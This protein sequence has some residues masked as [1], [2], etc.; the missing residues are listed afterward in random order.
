M[1]N[2]FQEP[3]NSPHRFLL[4]LSLVLAVDSV[5]ADI[6]RE[7]WLN[8]GGNS[9][10]DLTSSPDFPNRPDGTNIL[11]GFESPVNWADNFG[12]RVR[13]F[14]T[15]PVAGTYV[16]W[17]A[18]DDN[19]ELWLSTNDD[20]A[21][22]ALIASV[23]G[24]TGSGEWNKFPNQKSV[25]ISL[26]AGKRYYIEALHKEGGGGDNL[27]VGWA[28]P[29]QDTSVPSEV[30]PGA[31]LA[32]W[33]NDPNYNSSPTLHV[34][35]N[36]TLAEAPAVLHLMATV[37]DD[38][39]PFPTNPG[40][41]QPGDPHKLRW[42]WT[43]V[44]SPPESAGVGWSGNPT[45]GEAFTH[46]G[47]SNPPGTE[48]T[49]DPTA[50]FDVPGTYVLQFTASD[51][52]R[53]NTGTMTV[54]IKSSGAYRSLGYAYLS[55][56]PRSEYSS[57]QTRY[58]LLRFQDV[59][60][61]NILN[62]NQFISVTGAVSGVHSGQTVLASDGRT[63]RYI[64]NSDFYPNE[65]VTVSLK[66]VLRPGV[67]GSVSDYKFQFVIS[68]RFPDPGQITARGDSPPDNRKARAFDGN[69]STQ[70]LD[71]FVPGAE[72]GPSWIQFLYPGTET[73]IVTGYILASATNAPA[74]DPSDWNFYGVDSTGN[75]VLL[76][77][78]SGK[79][80]DRR[81]Q[82]VTNFFSNSID[83]R[84][85]RLEITGVRDPAT[86]TGVQLAEIQLLTASGTVL[87][88]YW[89]GINGTSVSDL[90]SDPRF[91][92]LP[93]GRD[94]LPTFEAPTDWA[95]N[96]GTRVRGFLHPPRTGDYTFW[97][98]S[99]DGSEL[100]LSTDDSPA[101]RVKIASVP[102]WTG[103]REW[104]K[105]PAQKSTPI[106]LVAG[107]SYYIEA[108]QKEGSGGDNLAVGW[109]K[110]GQPTDSP[111]QVIPG[112]SLT[113][114]V[115]TG[116]VSVRPNASSVADVTSSPPVQ[117]VPAES[118]SATPSR[119]MGLAN[120]P[121]LA[122][123]LSPT[124]PN[125][126][127]VPGDFPRIKIT[128]N[129]QPDPSPIFL[130]NRGGGG[131]P[132]NVIFDNSGSPIWYA[133]MPDER[134]DMK[135]QKNGV[136]TMLA[137]DNANHF[138]G[139]DTNYHLIKTYWADNGYGVDEHELQVLPDGHYFLIGLRGETVDMTRFIPNG[140]PSAGVTEQIIQEFTANDELIFQWRSWDHF[141]VRDQAQFIDITGGGFDF[142]HINAMDVDTDGNILISSRS[143]SE[144]TK[145]DRNTGQFIWRLG[146]NKNQM[147]FVNDPLQGP[148]N[149]HAIRSIGTNRYTLFDNGDLHNP[150]VS[151]AVEYQVDPVAM[152]ATVVW[153]YPKTP[154]PD[155]YSFYMGNVQRLLNG[156]TLI[157]WA[158]GNLPKLTEVRPDGTKAFEMN[159]VD[160]F[161]AY[162]VWRC[163]WKGV[164]T[165]PYLIVEPNPDN[166]TLTFNQFGDTNV[167]YYKI[168]GGTQPG[169]TTLLG[170]SRITRKAVSNLQNGQTYFFRVT[171]V[172]SK[173]VEGNYSN[174]ES[175]QVNLLRPGQNGIVNGDFSQGQSNWGL[176]LT[177]TAAGS[178]SVAAGVAHLSLTTAG[179]SIPSVGLQQSGVT[180]IQDAT[181]LLEFDAWASKS[182]I[183]Q[184]KL[185]RATTPSTDYS[186]IGFVSL[187]TAKTHFRYPFRMNQS[188]DP[189]ALLNLNVGPSVGD[190]FFQNVSLVRLSPGDFNR[191]GRVDWQDLK[192]LTGDW[193][194]S[195]SPNDLTSDGQVDLHDLDVLGQNWTGK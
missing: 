58:I 78:Q 157:N 33:T 2:N 94:L 45:S 160:G 17:I 59:A 20:P 154:T 152:T 87:R 179:A 22:Q 3:M 84:G 40:N 60:S 107:Q 76:D 99:D 139:F 140:N 135:V 12:E 86:A 175:I 44:S 62:F 128:M 28:R 66:P 149:Q 95:D 80:F 182:R 23:P 163:P 114:W 186:R 8:I 190:L 41:P 142:P 167:A 195:S 117:T 93:T 121:R 178:W 10:S 122:A 183:I 164:A 104:G 55:P 112:E 51:G 88:E 14:L 180:L 79:T 144:V 141:D 126:V 16:F 67:P 134:R 165:E 35:A 42:S 168:Y 138:N 38:G 6:L 61:S 64:M 170:E 145:I 100:W 83:F 101:N 188:T 71:P 171:A 143:L 169:S 177:D 156:N 111:S 129:N 123:A 92:D 176:A 96:Y 118:S 113:P 110:P 36:A 72:T 53:T 21:Q 147:T 116:G 174:E 50:R 26:S 15:P 136:L 137:R 162:R 27:A 131:H 125:G 49:S 106:A 184:P 166:I 120:Q 47:S 81:S 146:G 181:Y 151:R 29:G 105:D 5:R 68:G 32:P 109:A 161:E 39:K 65:V 30:I 13:G 70:W 1:H 7:Y 74:D 9:I 159:W 82:S 130:D 127:S 187:T 98:A 73:H 63:V 115:V 158:V 89:T 155:F 46:P 52:G 11:T 191:D 48:F 24:W 133:R 153:Q 103:S 57:P 150:S 172:N 18:S 69:P 31:V 91:P 97:I 34:Q 19:G 102:T 54:F 37:S 4:L 185:Q 189:S 124:F 75:Q 173:G 119:A 77:H 56:V 108:L 43:E 132:Y 25:P 148:R 194:K 193:L 192:T 85:Y 90:T